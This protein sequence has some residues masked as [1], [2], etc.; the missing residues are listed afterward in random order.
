MRRDALAVGALV[1]VTRLPFVAHWLWEWDSVLY[2]RA[3]EQGFFVSAD[4]AL[5][6]P[7]PPGYVLYVASAALARALLGDSNA[8]LVALAV[9][10]SAVTAALLYVLARRFAPRGI[11]LFAALAFA[12]DPLVW[13]HGEIALPYTVLALGST[14]L[15]LLCWDARS[16]TARRAL[17]LSA[18][19]GLAA[20]FRQDL[21]LL[22]GPLWLWSLASGGPRRIAQG[23]LAV[24][25]ASLAW[26]VP[27][28]LLSGG[29]AAY[30]AAVAA[31]TGSITGHSVA[32][33]G[34]EALWY[35]LRL[36][37]LALGWGL[38]VTGALLAVLLLA[39]A[40]HWLR[41]PRR[42][43]LGR[44]GAFFL[45]WLGPG[46]AV[47]L[48]W[49]IGDWGY[50][51]SLLPG[52]YVLS[53]LLLGRALAPI[54]GRG[55][56]LA[57]AGLGLVVGVAA[58]TFL[59]SDARWSRAALATHDDGLSFRVRAIRA[60][61]PAATTTLLARE[62]YLLARY[63]LAEYP[64]WL[65]DPA[66]A[67]PADPPKAMGGTVVVFTPDLRLRQPVVERL[68]GV[69][70]GSTLRI[71]ADGGALRLLGRD[72]IAREP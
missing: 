22:R 9:V 35:D 46:L 66:P 4:L 15:A 45:L 40:L 65:Y 36:V 71:V 44:T 7:H 55:R 27:S 51:L 8:A 50:V 26:L 28:A 3:L 24:G 47:Y 23:A 10:A 53:A 41:R 29:P 49:I 1:L 14:A 11:A 54:A 52:L 61:L 48:L 60:Q 13:A 57:H 62:D 6:R 21:L 39:P 59:V 31:Q 69:A 30:L 2:A 43:R 34:I 70:G 68:V 38:F 58:L 32:A 64:A 56:A 33:T 12:A 5:Q 17:A 63:Y 16:G 20:G 19:F 42:P 37:L 25:L 67:T 18:A 72:P